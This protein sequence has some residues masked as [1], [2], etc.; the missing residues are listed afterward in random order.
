MLIN[1]AIKANVGPCFLYAGPEVEQDTA[2]YKKENL[3]YFSLWL[4]APV[5]YTEGIYFIAFLPVRI[6]F[7][8]LR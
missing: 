5:D 1:R 2:G 8:Y 3:F 4:L 7:P 6:G